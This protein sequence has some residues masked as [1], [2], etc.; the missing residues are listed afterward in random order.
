MRIRRATVPPVAAL[1]LALAAAAAG[2]GPEGPGPAPAATGASGAPA[3]A[4]GAFD[5]AVAIAHRSREPYAATLE[6]TARTGEGESGE[7]LTV[8]GRVNTDTPAQ[9]SRTEEKTV[10][11]GSEVVAWTETLTADGVV[12]QR[13]K[14]KGETGWRTDPQSARGFRAD[15]D[16]VAAYAGLLLDS[17]PAARK[18][19]ET[20]SGVPVFH[21][22]AR[23]SPAQM[24]RVDPSVA[25]GTRGGGVAADCDLW[26]DRL[27]R[28]VRVR[29]AMVIDGMRTVTDDRFSAFGPAETFAPPLTAY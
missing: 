23:L 24:S 3:D 20:E 18:G 16:M 12:Y 13:D 22:G 1:A 29:Q 15:A 19:M 6:L 21:L 25:D 2:C 27:G 5:P 8:T 11:G 7:T 4:T 14:A 10:R 26:I 17:G 9:G 28:P